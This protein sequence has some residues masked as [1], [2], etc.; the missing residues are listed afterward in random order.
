M[1]LSYFYH[2]HD[3]NIDCVQDISGVTR[4]QLL[5]GPLAVR[6]AGRE[7]GVRVS[8]IAEMVNPLY[9]DPSFTVGKLSEQ[10]REII[11]K[12]VLITQVCIKS[13]S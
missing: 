12:L 1:N 2:N 11:I 4:G 7:A 13:D 9:P 5:P 10:D 6:R 3:K 8:A